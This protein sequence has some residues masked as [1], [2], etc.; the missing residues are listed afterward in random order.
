M[1]EIEG[2]EEVRARLGKELA[3]AEAA[4]AA[5]GDEARAADCEQAAAKLD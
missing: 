1:R 5:V 2:G 4:V 3:E